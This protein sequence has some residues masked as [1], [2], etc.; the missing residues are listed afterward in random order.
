LIILITY[1][2]RRVQVMKPLIVATNTHVKIE[3]LDPQFSMRSVS[4]QRD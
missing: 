2:W 4:Y 1:T 3:F